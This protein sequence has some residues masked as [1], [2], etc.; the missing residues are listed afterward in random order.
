MKQNASHK[1]KMSYIVLLVILL[2]VLLISM[3]LS[4]RSSRDATSPYGDDVTALEILSQSDRFVPQ[5]PQACVEDYVL[6]IPKLSRDSH[7]SFY[8]V[9][10]YC[11]VYL[12]E[13]LLYELSSSEH[14]MGS[15]TDGSVWAF[16]PIDREY[17]GKQ[18]RVE[19]TPVYGSSTERPVEFLLGPELDVY[20]TILKQNLMQLIL[21]LSVILIGLF[22]GGLAAYS[23]KHFETGK[24]LLYLGISS[25][26][27]GLWRVLDT[28]YLP[29]LFPEHTSL[30]YNI[31]LCALNF[32]TT[33]LIRSI[34]VHFNAR[35]RKIMEKFSFLAFV[36]ACALILCQL[37]GD[38]DLRE[39]LPIA[40]IVMISAALI[41]MGNLLYDALKYPDR[42][43]QNPFSLVSLIFLL[44]VFMDLWAFYV[45]KNSSDLVYTML[46]FFVY[47]LV[48][49]VYTVINFIWTEQK[50]AEKEAQLTRSRIT[51]MSSQIKAHFV[52]NI[53]NAISGMCK[54]DP[55]KADET[56]VLFARFLR[57]NI[58]I[59]QNDDN[60]VPFEQALK[61]L[62]D[63]VVLEQVRFGDGI[64]FEMDLQVSNFFLPSLV[65]QPLAENAIKHG[66]SPKD[67]CGTILLK[68]WQEDEMVYV[69]L[70]DNGVGFDVSDERKK[71]SVGLDNVRFRLEHLLGGSM[72]IESTV[73]EGTVVTLRI[74]R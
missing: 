45:E 48:M 15:K 55:A 49:G 5:A 73:G 68:T 36:I 23:I 3:S 32:I 42:W 40:H 59:L 46:S 28:R 25:V 8:L 22:F 7:L 29:L 69:S 47:S 24:S 38:W 27:V 63:Y 54:Y 41:L 11:S 62:E 74:P 65:L 61:Y 60:V 33:F 19:I 34:A 31:A 9:H 70:S 71:E 50:L 4:D 72:N 2:C 35:S 57:T 30:I 44:G 26:L 20:E 10:Q 56:I 16:L 12:G 64:Q 21:G 37:L 51:A 58:S 18:L 13:E 6:Q 52:F 53:L 66:L 39:S 17:S 1:N 67:Y 14:A 43:K